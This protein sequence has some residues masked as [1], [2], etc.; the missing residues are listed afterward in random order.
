MRCA[1]L[2][3]SETNKKVFATNHHSTFQ[4]LRHP[5][6]SRSSDEARDLPAKVF[7]AHALI[8]NRNGRRT[9]NETQERKIRSVA[10]RENP[11]QTFLQTRMRRRASHPAPHR[12]CVPDLP[13]HRAC[14]VMILQPATPAE[15][16]ATFAEASRRFAIPDLSSEDHE[17]R[18]AA[19]IPAVSG[20]RP[21]RPGNQPR[22]RAFLEVSPG[23]SL[24]PITG[25]R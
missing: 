20:R 13:C 21:Q 25:H 22:L 23:D 8:C 12:A 5:E 24:S 14:G 10:I 19:A 15:A 17:P 16:G 11:W 18:A 3:N 4:R 1:A 2:E 6:R 7:P 9:N